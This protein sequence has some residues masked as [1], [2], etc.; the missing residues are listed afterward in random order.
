MSE[1][2]H[3]NATQ[4]LPDDREEL[5]HLVWREPAEKITSLYS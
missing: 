3:T 1:S 5:Y 2:L 4:T